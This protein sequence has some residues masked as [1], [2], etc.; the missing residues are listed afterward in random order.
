MRAA[1]MTHVLQC[2]MSRRQARKEPVSAPT[3]SHPR[4]DA[5]SR[6]QSVRLDAVF[7]RQVQ[8]AAAHEG[9]SVSDFIRDA[10]KERTERV[11]G[12]VS[13]WDRI[14]PIVESMPRS[15]QTTDTASRTHEAF[16]EAVASRHA[17]RNAL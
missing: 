13:L 16:A 10:V 17:Q 8:A 15:G 1:C 6:P 3:D 14:R 2:A 5:G 7:E 12:T 9:V 4:Q 11:L